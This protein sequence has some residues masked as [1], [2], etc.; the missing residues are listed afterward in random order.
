MAN[1]R[2]NNGQSPSPTFAKGLETHRHFYVNEGSVSV[3]AEVGCQVPPWERRFQQQPAM[4]LPFLRTR[5]S[6]HL[7]QCL[8]SVRFYAVLPSRKRAPIQKQRLAKAPKLPDNASEAEI[9]ELRLKVQQEQLR[10]VE[11]EA[12]R[13]NRRRVD[14]HAITVPL[15]GSCLPVREAIRLYLTRLSALHIPQRT[16]SFIL[17]GQL[18]IARKVWFREV[19]ERFKDALQ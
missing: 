2:Y 4:I 14:V 1:R 12:A 18:N 6:K 11:M 19:L 17:S 7:T 5:D 3:E 16:L 9:N 8:G 15:L 10:M 13:G